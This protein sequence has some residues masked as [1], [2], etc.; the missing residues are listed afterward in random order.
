VYQGV[1][2]RLDAADVAAINGFAAG[3]RRP[4]IT[5]LLDLPTGVALER[6]RLRERWANLPLDRMERELPAFY[7]Q[8]RQGYL[9]LAGA[10]PERFVVVNA[11]GTP[12]DIALFIWT[13]LTDRFHGLCPTDCA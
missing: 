4:D 2:R 11:A 7:E 13:T 5:F 9:D 12:D 8:V 10:H 3:K 6:L 1:A